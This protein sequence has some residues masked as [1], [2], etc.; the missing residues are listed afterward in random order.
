MIFTQTPSPEDPIT[1][2]ARLEAVAKDC[3]VDGEPRTDLGWVA[4]VVQ[5]ALGAEV[6]L[7]TALDAERQY[8]L[9]QHGLERDLP[10]TPL[11][12]SLCRFV[13][14][15]DAPLVVHDAAAHKLLSGHPAVTDLGVASYAGVPVRSP[16]GPTLGALCVL[17]H[18]PRIW[19]AQ[20]LGDL[21]VFAAIVRDEIDL[22]V[23][24]SRAPGVG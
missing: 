17:G 18:M 3:F 21:E 23:R 16:S 1:A 14:E 24:H 20:N 6:A 8:F 4:G 5:R 2:R 22:G 15:R 7:L 9:S 11:E 12:Q 13:V 19:T 10:G